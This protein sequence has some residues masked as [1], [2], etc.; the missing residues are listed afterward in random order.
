MFK[1]LSIKSRL[2][3]VVGVL[4]LLLLMIGIMGLVGMSKANEGLGTENEHNAVAS[5]HIAQIE[6]LILDER[7]QLSLVMLG[8]TSAEINRQT[9]VVEKHIEQISKIWNAYLNTDLSPQKRVVADKFAKDHAR[10]VEEGLRPLIA[11]LREGKIKDSRVFNGA[12]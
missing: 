6:S 11:M 4:S 10:F 3:L 5:S 1:D 2:T 9:E 7:L 12:K 8:H